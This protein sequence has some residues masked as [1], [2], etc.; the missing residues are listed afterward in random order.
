MTLTP[1]F[2]LSHLRALILIMVG[3]LL[4]G[5]IHAQEMRLSMEGGPE[6]WR[7]TGIAQNQQIA[8]TKLPTMLFE[9]TGTVRGGEVVANL[10]C[11]KLLGERWCRVEKLSGTRAK[12]YI[13]QKYLT[14]APQRPT[15]PTPDDS[16]A[17]GPDAWQVTGLKP[18][19][20][21]NIRSMP[22]AQSRVLG[23]LRNGET[24]RNLGCRME[25]STR[26]CKI[27]TYS[28]P[29]ITGYVNGRYLREGAAPPPPKPLPD[30]N[31]TGGPDYWRVRGL[32]PGD[33]LNV[34]QA[35]STSSRVLA[36]L[37]EGERVRN[38]GCQM[39][40]KTRWCLI[41]STTGMDVT[42]YVAGAY[43]RE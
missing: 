19:D 42:G 37:R 25:G 30:D 9:T 35:P 41:R 10:G 32:K 23:S 17:G 16:L 27:R 18:N 28:A 21:L 13:A 1:A 40:G 4:P 31:L 20:R 39:S 43:L 12:G 14:P 11:G 6:R 26:W 29:N 34:R 2:V 15:D 5:A 7:V 22:S 24:V 38:L 8:L 36:T 33:T 3:V